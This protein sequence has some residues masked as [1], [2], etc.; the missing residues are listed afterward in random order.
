[1][2]APYLYVVRTYTKRAC[3]YTPRFRAWRQRAVF[4]RGGRIRSGARAR[5]L[6]WLA[7][8]RVFWFAH[9]ID[10][11]CWHIDAQDT[12]RAFAKSYVFY[13]KSEWVCEEWMEKRKGGEK[14]S[15][16][17][18]S[19]RER[20]SHHARKRWPVRALETE[21][22]GGGSLWTARNLMVPSLRRSNF[23]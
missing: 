11:E 4:F 18:N 3:I 6:F 14:G 23:L 7:E 19:I 5:I 15:R 13:E 2:P 16:E 17:N 20:Q 9:G 8:R 12:Y 21:R 10:L 1:M 22:R